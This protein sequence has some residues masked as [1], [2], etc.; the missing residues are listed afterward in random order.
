MVFGERG[1][2]HEQDGEM[3]FAIESRPITAASDPAMACKPP[4]RR[5]GAD[6]GRS[7]Y[8]QRSSLPVEQRTRTSALLGLSMI[9]KSVSTLGSN[10]GAGFFAI[11]LDAREMCA[12]RII[13][14]RIPSLSINV[15]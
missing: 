4:P 7:K 12:R 15:L 10:P 5:T 3:L 11:T 6:C 1:E 2:G 13:Q 14:R 9:G 8:R